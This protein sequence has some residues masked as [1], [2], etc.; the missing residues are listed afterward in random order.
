MFAAC[1]GQDDAPG[2]V[3]FESGGTGGTRT[4][5]ESCEDGAS[6]DCSITLGRHG[7]V[8]SC[9]HGT[10][11][12]V[13]GVWQACSN[14]SVK[15]QAA[16][17]FLSEPGLMPL[18]LSDAAD[19]EDN[20]C[21]PYCQQF[22]EEPDEPLIAEEGESEYNWEGGSLTGFPNGLVKKGLI[23]PCET[24]A[25]CQFN[26]RCVAPDA[27]NCTHGVC[28]EG[29]A[30]D[31]ECNDCAEIVCAEE[32][33][34]CGFDASD[35]DVG[36]CDH[37]PC[38][39]GEGLDEDC[40]GCVA[41]I[42][43]T[44]PDCCDTKGSNDNWDATCVAA[45]ASICGNTCECASDERTYGGSCYY[46]ETTDDE[47]DDALDACEDRGTGWSLATIDSS[48]E[49]AEI[50]SWGWAT[51]RYIGFGEKSNY[52]KWE[53]DPDLGWYYESNG[54]KSSSSFYTNWDSGYP[55]G[56][57]PDCAYMRG[58]TGKW[59][60]ETSC[61]SVKRD[62]V[63]EGSTSVMVAG[64]GSGGP[65]TWDSSCVALADTLCDIDCNADD[66]TDTSGTCMPWYPGETDPNCDGVDLSVAPPC[67]G[68]IPVCNHGNLTALAPI[69]LKHYPA[70]SQ[71]FPTCSPDPHAQ[72]VTCTINQDIPP[73]HCV[74]VT[75]ADCDDDLGGNR[76]IMVNPGGDQ[77][78]TPNGYVDECSCLDNWSLYGNKAVSC[79]APVCA[80][81]STSASKV[82]K[83]VDIILIVD[84][85]PSMDDEI[86]EV[87]DRINSD[88]AQILADSNLDYRVILV[89]RFGDVNTR[90]GTS[91]V[92]ICIG[93]PLGANA[94]TDAANE[95][96][97]NNAPHFYHFSTEIE[98]TDSWCQLLYGFDHADEIG[99]T[100]D[101]WSGT[102]TARTWTSLVPDGWGSL[103]REEAFKHFVI[104][105]DDDIDCSDYGYDFDDSPDCEDFPHNCHDLSTQTV[106]DSS[107]TAGES[108][109]EDFDEALLAL[110]PEQFGTSSD[111]NYVWHSIINIRRNPEGDQVPWQPEDDMQTEMCTPAWTSIVGAGTGYQALSRLTGGLRYPIC[112][113]D[114]FDAIF[115]AI[116]EEV[117]DTAGATCDFA[118]SATDT[119]DPDKATVSWTDKNDDAH[120]LDQ[121][122][123]SA[124]C[125]SST[126]S[127][128]YD[129]PSDPTTLSLCPSTCED[130]QSDSEALVWV[131]FGCPGSPEPTTTT[132]TYEASC[133]EG[134][135]PQW[136]FL[137]YDTT[138]EATDGGSVSFRVRAAE[139]EADLEDATWL[140]AA[141]ATGDEP[142]CDKGNPIDGV[143]PADLYDLLGSDAKLEFVELEVTVT[144]DGDNSPSV[145]NWEV[146]YS[147]PEGE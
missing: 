40:N 115:N 125:G 70:N 113:N 18:A 139:S 35:A 2:L 141:T 144:P 83:P 27:G 146:T 57:D 15:E 128:Y 120:A 98:S 99:T 130:V 102:G 133:P 17:S 72:E 131:E 9:Y 39:L 19:C 137:F 30:L 31:D 24:G 4:S 96:L 36:A 42:C 109:A 69:E 60:G 43:Q 105:S 138:I 117:I 68:T 119:Y 111:R 106:P 23:E 77:I 11:V 44:Y 55:Q 74:E 112:E 16:P 123:S 10:Q 32:A 47:W 101:S 58:S 95:T 145:E 118:L 97:E 104:I 26:M 63:C 3:G 6:Q 56:G 143:C 124:D 7:N 64:G 49:N 59:R 121:V 21:D 75:N 87:Q 103:L 100:D 65:T 108:A 88:L 116:A 89:S 12:C 79:S 8:L 29:E 48:D 136:Q 34:C 54:S 78:N 37:G 52:W 142:D 127:W 51:D 22:T 85:S 45:V 81:G 41:A 25:D 147:C 132:E 140:D 94:C 66:S 92:N 84:N 62:Y 53:G 122:A 38:E 135:F 14:G 67:E 126:S 61:T 114:N 107:V 90:V 33:G 50:Q 134:Q 5:G 76:E 91:A 80:G 86:E 20:P 110:S 73:G 71:Q 28:E 82:T 1:G 46:L 129:D 93:E 13:D